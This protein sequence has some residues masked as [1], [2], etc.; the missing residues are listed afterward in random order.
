MSMQPFDL[1]GS[2]P[3]I[4]IWLALGAV[5]IVI[6]AY[7]RNTRLVFGYYTGTLALTGLLAALTAYHKTTAFQHW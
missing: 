7:V 4:V 1:V 5:G 2:L 6:Q 3:L